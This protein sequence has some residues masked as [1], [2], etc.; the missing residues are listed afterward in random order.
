MPKF[1]RRRKSPKIGTGLR[2][3][4]KYLLKEGIIEELS[5]ESIP[6]SPSYPT[7]SQVSKFVTELA[8]SVLRDCQLAKLMES[9]IA[10]NPEWNVAD[11]QEPPTTT[12]IVNTE[13]DT[14]G[15]VTAP[16]NN[17]QRENPAI[18]QLPNSK[19]W[20]IMRNHN[21]HSRSTNIYVPSFYKI[22]MKRMLDALRYSRSMSLDATAYVM[23]SG[24]VG[25]SAFM[26]FVIYE[27]M[28]QDPCN[29]YLYVPRPRNH[30]AEMLFNDKIYFI[31][32]LQEAIDV[33]GRVWDVKDGAGYIIYD[34]QCP[35]E[36]AFIPGYYVNVILLASY[37]IE[38]SERNIRKWCERAEWRFVMPPWELQDI[39]AMAEMCYSSFDQKEVVKQFNLYG[40]KPRYIFMSPKK[41]EDEE[42]SLLCELG[43]IDIERAFQNVGFS[44][45]GDEAYTGI[46]FRILPGPLPPKTAMG[47]SYRR[48]AFILDWAS[49]IILDHAVKSLLSLS[50]DRIRTLI[51]SSTF[52]TSLAS[53]RGVLFERIFHKII[54]T[55]PL[56]LPW[57][58]LQH[59]TGTSFPEILRLRPTTMCLF[60]NINEIR[61][62]E[63][64][65][66][67]NQNFAGIS[68]TTKKAAFNGKLVLSGLISS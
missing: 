27:I 14:D 26:N 53:L 25:K 52:D 46:L 10:R 54:Q 4:I 32:D 49:E 33:I 16:H 36:L 13:A 56:N 57:R 15:D 60:R 24:G 38:N 51:Q 48:Q 35:R 21:A 44:H 12:N 28:R 45:P 23:G 41:E 11:G 42:K 3:G 50:V 6:P 65:I 61:Q 7:S 31:I 20:H 34:S 43:R 55:T 18:L 63:Y 64:N 17:S 66:P 67:L 5:G 47:Y 8:H 39:L 68:P 40:G 1:S 29:W 37:G 22:I 59:D 9:T 62:S 2:A 19:S 30:G 58:P